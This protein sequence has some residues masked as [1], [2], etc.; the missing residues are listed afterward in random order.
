MRTFIALLFVCCFT[1]SGCATSGHVRS[2]VI[3]GKLLD[4][5]NAP[6]CVSTQSENERH[7]ME[8]ISFS[9][10]VQDAQSTIISIIKGMKNSE[11]ITVSEDYV[12]VQFKTSVF[13]FIDDVEFYF[14]SKEKLIHFR[15]SAR[16]GYYDWKVN[17]KRM[18]YVVEEF[19]KSSN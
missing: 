16:F 12:Y 3:G 6:K 2:G 10:R 13:R 18:E 14:D 17:R 15:S 7:R 5:P 8:P 1:V 11:I 19:Y 9:G 4:C